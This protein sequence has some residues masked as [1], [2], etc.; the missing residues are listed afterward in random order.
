MNLIVANDVSRKGVGFGAET[1]E[2]FIVDKGRNVIHLDTRSKND[3]AKAIL[4][5]VN[6]NLG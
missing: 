2:V 3:I 1:N 5:R 6:S 4:D